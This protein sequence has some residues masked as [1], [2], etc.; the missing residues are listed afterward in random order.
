MDTARTWLQ[1][2]QEKILNKFNEVLFKEAWDKY[3]QGSISSWEMEALCF[4]YHEHELINV[5]TTKYGIVDFY[6]QSTQPQVDYFFKRNGHEI[7][8]YKLNKIIGTV[9]GK[10]DSRHSISLLTTSGVV[11]VKFTGEY[12]SMFKKQ[13]SQVNPDG[14]KK[15]I[16]K[17]WFKRGTMLMVQGYRIDDQWRAKNYKNAGG[18]QLYKI[19]NVVDKDILL[20]H[21]R[22]SGIMEEEVYDE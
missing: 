12:Y 15:V 13:I 16:E 2:N 5:D 18:H 8:I 22:Q 10:N 17:S 9:I 4:Y 20:Q 19:I 6:E 3:A 7:P 14:S 21:E 11:N 1:E